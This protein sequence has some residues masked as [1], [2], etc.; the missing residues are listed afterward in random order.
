MSGALLPTDPAVIVVAHR[1]HSG[2]PDYDRGIRD[3]MSEARRHPSDALGAAYWTWRAL[4]L[5]WL[6]LMECRYGGDIDQFHYARH[7][8]VETLERIGTPKSGVEY[9]RSAAMQ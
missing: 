8:A 5:A 3:H 2:H 7:R 9:A 4:T 6:H 1:G